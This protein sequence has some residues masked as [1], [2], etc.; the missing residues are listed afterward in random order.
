MILVDKLAFVVPDT[1]N[2]AIQRCVEPKC[3]RRF[4]LNERLYVCSTCGGL[5]DV[6]SE[7][8]TDWHPQELRDVWQRQ[9]DLI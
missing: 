1:A 4:A 3:R 2:T 6:V 8:T 7:G 9:A 5:L